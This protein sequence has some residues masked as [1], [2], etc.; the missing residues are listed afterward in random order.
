LPLVVAIDSGSTAST[1]LNGVQ[2]QADKYSTGGTANSTADPV[3]GGALYSTERY[4]AFSYEVPVTANGRYTVVLH[5]AEI[6]QTATGA[7]SFNVLIEGNN[8]VSNLDIFSKAG[9]DTGYSVTID[10]IPVVDGKVT[11]ELVKGVENPTIAGFAIYSRDG[12]L[13]TSVVSTPTV[14]LSKYSA[15]VGKATEKKNYDL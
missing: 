13:D 5:F 7:R 10:D 9:Q 6:Y 1:T 11:I 3:S 14:D 15:Y 4:G 12:K 2:Y 8:V